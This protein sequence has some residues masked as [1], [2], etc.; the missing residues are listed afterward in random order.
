MGY[1][2]QKL[3]RSSRFESAPIFLAIGMGGSCYFFPWRDALVGAWL[4]CVCDGAAAILGMKY[5]R[6]KIAG[7]KKTY[8]GSLFFF[9]TG[10]IGLVPLTGWGTGIFISLIGMLVELVSF[11][12]RDN[13]F[14]P[15]AGTILAFFL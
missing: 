12:G 11:K 5:G 1:I 8:W 15:I 13:L 10:I 4:V 9:L 14:L 6:K 3:A 2:T 7:T